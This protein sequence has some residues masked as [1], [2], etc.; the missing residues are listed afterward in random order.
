M[1]NRWTPIEN[2]LHE[3]SALHYPDNTMRRILEPLLNGLFDAVEEEMN[4][5]IYECFL[6][7]STGQYLDLF[8]VEIGLTRENDESDNEYRQ[9]LFNAL[10]EYL[11]VSFVK[12]QGIILYAKEELWL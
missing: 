10:S 5:I 3:E 9:R 8:G 12:L 11:S 2:R 4:D 1:T 7:T 6:L